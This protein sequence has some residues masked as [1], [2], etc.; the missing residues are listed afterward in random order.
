MTAE[1]I[2][3]AKAKGARIER[4]TRNVELQGLTALVAEF[5]RMADS[6]DTI[7]QKRND[8]LLEAISNLTEAV[9]QQELK[10]SDINVDLTPIAEI[11]E[12]LQKPVQRVPYDF[13]VERDQRGLMKN[14]R[15]IPVELH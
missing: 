13:N 9:K 2:A 8:D 7:A 10:G 1:Q 6:V 4:E 11:I 3:Q 12:E 15:A 5:K 14:V